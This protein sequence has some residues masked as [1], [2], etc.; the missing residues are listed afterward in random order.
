[1][2]SPTNE[3]SR[4]VYGVRNEVWSVGN[5]TIGSHLLAAMGKCP[6]AASTKP[7]DP[8][9]MAMR[10]THRRPRKTHQ[11]A[12]PGVRIPPYPADLWA[13][14]CWP[15][16]QPRIDAAWTSRSARPARQGNESRRCGHPASGATRVHRPSL[17][18]RRFAP[19]YQRPAPDAC[20][21]RGRAEAARGR[22]RPSP[23]MAMSQWPPVGISS[24]P[25]TTPVRN[26]IS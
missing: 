22:P 21:P 24:W 15:V 20:P 4:G 16:G 8:P 2:T 13:F 10:T 25:L 5:C 14:P 26:G 11:S 23:H 17:R 18:Q 9:G 1:M 19:G 6:L 7:L 3:Q 12:A